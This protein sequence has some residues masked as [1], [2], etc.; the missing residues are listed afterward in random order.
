MILLLIIITIIT[1]S[2]NDNS[3]NDLERAPHH[4]PDGRHLREVRRIAPQVA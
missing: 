4:V 1:N 3:N 2:N